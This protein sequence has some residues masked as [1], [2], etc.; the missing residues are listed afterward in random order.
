MDLNAE[1]SLPHNAGVKTLYESDLEDENY[2]SVESYG[3][4]ERRR[5][6]H[7]EAEQRRRNAIKRGFEGLL[8]LVHPMKNES[9]SPSVRMSKSS[10]LH[11]AIY[12]IERLGKQKHQKLSEAESLEKEV[13]ALRILCLN[14]E[15]IVQNSPNYELFRVFFDTM[16]RSF[17][18]YIVFSSF[19]DLSASVIKWIEESCK[20]E[21][22]AFLMDSVLTNIFN[23][24][25]E[26]SSVSSR[27]LQ[28]DTS[29]IYTDCSTNDSQNR[30]ESI[31]SIHPSA[32]SLLQ[33]NPL[34]GQ[35]SVYTYSSNNLQT[36][37]LAPTTNINNSTVSTEKR[38][39][40][41]PKFPI[42]P[43][44]NSHS[45]KLNI[46]RC[47]P[48]LPSAPDSVTTQPQVSHID[49]NFQ[50]CGQPSKDIREGDNAF[51]NFNSMIPKNGNSTVIVIDQSSLL[52]DDQAKHDITSTS[53]SSS[54][55]PHIIN[56]SCNLIMN[57]RNLPRELS[58]LHNSSHVQQ[59]KEFIDDLL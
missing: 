51:Y 17:D 28:C 19:T 5:K 7:T 25:T 53:S 44:G 9:L 39:Q 23:Q 4:R 24:T 43:Q 49:V 34:I 12:M 45:N 30:S 54:S 47:P 3:I 20:P 40:L 18:N 58:S 31:G 55:S 35:S 52:T 33:I 48:L 6:L 10:I 2:S 46:V 14:Y 21:K 27:K 59:Y 13:K 41:N 36:L 56:S 42:I 50:Q 29:P 15:K 22:M 16:F 38:T 11:K 8:E 1:I 37:T 32:E 57:E 26:M